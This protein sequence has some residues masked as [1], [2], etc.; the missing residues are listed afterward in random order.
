[1]SVRRLFAHVTD[2]SNRVSLVLPV[3]VPSFGGTNVVARLL[4]QS[5]TQAVDL[6]LQ[7]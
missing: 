5:L 6:S 1:M 7:D 2:Y 4:F 3:Q